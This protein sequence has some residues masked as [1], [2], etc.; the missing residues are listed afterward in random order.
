MKKLTGIP[1]LIWAL[2]ILAG[3]FAVYAQYTS[4]NLST[5]EPKI[6][7]RVGE[8]CYEPYGAPVKPEFK[9]KHVIVT[10]TWVDGPINWNGEAVAGLSQYSY[11][12]GSDTSICRV[13]IPMPE[14][15]LGDD[16]MDTIGHEILH[17]VVGAFHE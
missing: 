13:W 12:E 3:I 11:D 17:C 9:A 8:V 1:A 16:R 2:A 6:T 7:H 10:I 4:K 15:V 5:L 14:R